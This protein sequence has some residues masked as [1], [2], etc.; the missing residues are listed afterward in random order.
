[1]N[2]NRARHGGLGSVLGVVV[3]L[4]LLL[5]V[6]VWLGDWAVDCSEGC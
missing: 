6:V 1:M 4:L 5:D 3:V 2:R